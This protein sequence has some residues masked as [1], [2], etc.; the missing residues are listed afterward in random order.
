VHKT[1]MR[2][3]RT[4]GWR[5]LLVAALGAA[6]LIVPGV[7]ASAASAETT[8]LCKPGIA[9]NPCESSLTTTVQLANG[10]SFVENAKDNTNAP[11]DCFYVYPTVSS[12][13]GPNATETVEPEETQIAIDQASRFSQAC[14]VYAPIY[15]QL[16]IPAINTPG[17]VTPADS[18]K[19]YIGVLTAFEEYLAR[20]NNGRGFVL[21]GHSQGSLMLEQLIKEQIDPNPALRKLLV[22]ADLLGGNVLVPKGKTAGASFQNVPTCQFAGQTHCLIAYSSFLKEP[23]NPSFFGRV[24]SPLLG[25]PIPEEIAK[26]LE[27]VCTNPSAIVGNYAGPLFRYES[28]SPFPGLLAPF[29]KAPK[30][31]TPW[32][33]M[34]GQYSG[35]CMRA[36]GATWLQ[37]TPAGGPEDKREAI[38][39]VL[40]PLWGTHLEDVNVAL[41]N[42]VANTAIQSAV[43]Q[44]TH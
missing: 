43:Y 34:P 2:S 42:L 10:Q 39:E 16:T 36:N 28:T 14:K 4:V 6:A 35:Q 41:G 37:L 20:Y 27:V 29:V 7:A 21:L 1:T 11:I 44:V 38:V 3:T 26:T 33:S 23:P 40:G 22:S 30:G 13:P 31:S 18:A 12:Q 17:A 9:N 15:P 32:V 24:N 5:S 25:T 19:A 8:W